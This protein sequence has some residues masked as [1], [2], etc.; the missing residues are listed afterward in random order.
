MRYMQRTSF[1]VRS[2]IPRDGHFAPIC[3]LQFSTR[4]DLAE[5]GR[6]LDD[7]TYFVIVFRCRPSNDASYVPKRSRHFKSSLLAS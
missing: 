6:A 7:N 5:R 3:G 2:G 1:L 4:R